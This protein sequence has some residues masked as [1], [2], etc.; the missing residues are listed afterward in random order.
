MS[1][2]ELHASSD[3]IIMEKKKTKQANKNH[4]NDFL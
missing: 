2:D 1:W 4:L 3:R